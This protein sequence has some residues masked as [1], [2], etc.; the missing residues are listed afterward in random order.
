MFSPC[1]ANIQGS[2]LVLNTTIN[3][4]KWDSNLKFSFFKTTY[5]PHY[6]TFTHPL[7]VKQ[8]WLLGQSN[9]NA[10]IYK[11]YKIFLLYGK[12]SFFIQSLLL[13]FDFSM[14]ALT[15]YH[16]QPCLKIGFNISVQHINFPFVPKTSTYFVYILLCVYQ[17][18][19]GYFENMM[20]I[21]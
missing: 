7:P 5:K 21:G 2:L 13:E 20:G 8:P 15:T 9:S 14:Q 11:F 1:L 3:C 4:W 16:L 10:G 12:N 18:I 6:L 19:L 17:I